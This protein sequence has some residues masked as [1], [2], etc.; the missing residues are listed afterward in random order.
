[1]IVLS[2]NDENYY[3]QSRNTVVLWQYCTCNFILN[4]IP[5]M[6]ASFTSLEFCKLRGEVTVSPLIWMFLWINW[7]QMLFDSIPSNV[8]AYSSSFKL[9]Y[10]YI[11]KVSFVTNLC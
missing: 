5:L 7:S 11:S 3:F 8:A 6:N 9:N 2:A 1:M 10:K 4:S